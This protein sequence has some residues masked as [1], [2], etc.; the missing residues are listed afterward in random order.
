NQIVV[1]IEGFAASL[2]GRL[3]KWTE[4]C[5]RCIEGFAESLP[6]R[7]ATLTQEFVRWA[8]GAPGGTATAIAEAGG[9]GK[10]EKQVEN[11]W[12]P[13]LI[14]A[15]GRALLNLALAIPGMV[16]KIGWALLSSFARILIDLALMA[17]EKFRHLL[18]V[19]ARLWEQIKQKII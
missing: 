11:D 16:V 18:G 9:P 13:R 4:R 7:L 19:A 6:A 12:A 17:A 5:V 2:P 10:I 15:F 14:A 8:P 1:W 3:E